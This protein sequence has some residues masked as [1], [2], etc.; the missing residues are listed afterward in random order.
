MGGELAR[1]DG[2]YGGFA[3]VLGGGGTLLAEADEAVVD[4]A[5]VGGAPSARARGEDCDFRGDDGVREV[6]QGAGWDRGVGRRS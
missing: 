5:G 3:E 2:R 4:A 6:G 1:E